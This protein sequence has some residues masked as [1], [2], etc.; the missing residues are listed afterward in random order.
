MPKNQRFFQSM[1]LQGAACG[2][3]AAILFGLSSPLAKLFLLGSDP[4]LLVALL[5]LGA[6]IGL[7]LFERLV[8]GSG[9]ASR[10][11]HETPLN[12]EDARLLLGILITGGVLGPILLLSLGSGSRR[13]LG[14]IY[15]AWT[16]L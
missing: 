2:L 3:A 12:R 10:I 7:L 16:A 14:R 15:K 1:V 8:P 11:R 5:Y 4:V 6:G 13:Y 9:T